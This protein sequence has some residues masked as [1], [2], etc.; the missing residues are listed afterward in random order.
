MG[1][2]AQFAVPAINHLL[3][4]QS[5]ARQRLAPFSGEVVAC[6]SGEFSFQCQI[7]NGGWLQIDQEGKAP[8]VH[9][10]ADLRELIAASG[11]RADLLSKLHISGNAGLADALSFVAQNLR[12]DLESDLAAYLGDIP[13]HR[14][15]MALKSLTQFGRDAAVGL[16]KNCR[17]YMVE[18]KRL[19]AN[20]DEL[21]TFSREV[22]EIRDGT[23]RL[24]KRI[25]RL[26]LQGK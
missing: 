1:F 10:Q 2:T 19:V 8:S 3:S 7:A 9:V 6:S 17:E 14:L 16:A 22:T 23:S 25:E 11:T 4:Q 12:W 24:D 21:A 15:G 26:L 18:E 5:W 13:A 20:N